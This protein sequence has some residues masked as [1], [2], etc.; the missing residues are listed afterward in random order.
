[1]KATVVGKLK[2]PYSID[3]KSG[4]SCRVSLFCGEYNSDPVAGSSG[5]GERYLEVRCP[6][7]IFDSFSLADDVSVE[8]DDKESRIKSA[9]IKVLVGDK[10][11]Y[12][13]IED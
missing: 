7:D 4:I 5:E 1:M 3:G 8:L 10:Y 12:L 13:P 9:M 6:L 2:K 11:A